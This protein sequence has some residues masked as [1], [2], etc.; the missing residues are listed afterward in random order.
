MND[1]DRIV[2]ALYRIADAIGSL[3]FVLFISAV[4]VTCSV[5]PK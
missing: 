1:T 3:T 4:M 2:A 5:A